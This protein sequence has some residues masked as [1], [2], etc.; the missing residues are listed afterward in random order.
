M[1]QR[2]RLEVVKSPRITLLI[3]ERRSLFF[4]F[5]GIILKNQK[6]KETR[7][8]RTSTCYGTGGTQKRERL[9]DKSA[10]SLHQ[11]LQYYTIYKVDSIL[12]FFSSF[13]F[14][15]PYGNKSLPRQSFFAVFFCGTFFS[16]WNHSPV[17][18]KDSWGRSRRTIQGMRLIIIRYSFLSYVERRMMEI[19]GGKK[20]K[21]GRKSLRSPNALE[22][23]QKCTNGK[24]THP[25]GCVQHPSPFSISPD[26]FRVSLSTVYVS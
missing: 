15:S 23:K 18:N 13:S 26:G 19:R 14:L 1:L 25:V 12:I 9:G 11:Q 6:E 22:R 8:Y 21:S 16:A 20:Q 4:A 3:P 10:A 24:W 7:Q 2:Y 17:E 5:L